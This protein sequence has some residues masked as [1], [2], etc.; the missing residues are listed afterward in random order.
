M[1]QNNVNVGD[2]FEY[3]GNFYHYIGEIK[4]KMWVFGGWRG[5]TPWGIKR[6]W[7]DCVHYYNSEGP[8]AREKNEFFKRFKKQ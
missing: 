2:R 1:E 5:K 7:V 8:Y 4:V 3:K 6:A